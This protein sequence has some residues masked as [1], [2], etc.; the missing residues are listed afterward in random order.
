MKLRKLIAIVP[1][2]AVVSLAFGQDETELHPS[3]HERMEQEV[4]KHRTQVVKR[5]NTLPILE[6][7]FDFLN[8]G[9]Q[10]R[11]VV[12]LGFTVRPV[13]KTDAEGAVKQL[14]WV[15]NVVN[16]IL[17]LP[18]NP[19]DKEIRVRSLAILRSTVPQAFPENHADIRIETLRGDVTLVGF[20]SEIESKRLENAIVRIQH[21][22]FVKKVTN[23]VIVRSK[24]S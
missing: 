3:S 17:V 23:N 15:E 19:E 21:L 16:E 12:L 20:I 4:Q 13:L 24:E 6:T 14:S 5:L 7:P 10:G 8:F 18:L 22:P 2:I 11:T 1:I 9:I